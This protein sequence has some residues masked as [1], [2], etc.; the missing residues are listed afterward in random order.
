MISAIVSHHFSGTY[1]EARNKFLTA[2]SDRG[3]TIESFPLPG[4]RGALD[5][6]LA[7]DVAC[8]GARD[9]SRLLIL[10]SGTH[11]PE[12]FCGSGCQVAALHDDD[13]LGLLERSGIRLVMIH[14]INPYG[15]SHIQRNNQNN[16]DLNRN[17]ID[18]G[19]PLPAN[20]AYAVVDPLA[21]PATWPPTQDDDRAMAAYLE[22]Y[23]VSAYHAAL[24]SGQYHQPDGMF[25]GGREPTWNNRTVRTILRRYCT[26]AQHIGWIDVHTGLGP[27]GHGEKIYAGRVSTADLAIARSWWGADVFAPFEGQSESPEV[28]GPVVSTVY[29]ECPQAA[30]G[31]IALE[32]GTL[33]FQEILFH[34]RASQWLVR[35][36]ELPASVQRDIRRRLLDAYYC[37]ND[38]WKG[39]V[40]AQARTALVQALSGLAKAPLA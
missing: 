6:E 22:Q 4:Y 35:H 5:E 36:P 39:A 30:I 10:S 31:L 3:A 33:P 15:F 9:A 25:Y 21:L 1:V 24:A 2:A 32:I 12:G 20:P 18:F 7:I 38:A 23:G 11:G 28:S 17:H 16:V 26:G 29:D 27:N 14:G 13:L 37:D 40:W 34:L 19:K 8:L